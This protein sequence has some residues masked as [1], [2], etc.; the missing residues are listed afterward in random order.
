MNFRCSS[1]LWYDDHLSDCVVNHYLSTLIPLTACLASA[2][3]CLISYF[4]ARQNAKHIDTGFHP[5]ASSEDE[6][7]DQIAHVSQQ[8][9]TAIPPVIE[10]LEVALILA[11]ISIAIFLLIFSG[12]NTDLTSVFASAVSSIYLLLILFVRLTRSL[13]SY[14]DLQPHSSVLYTLQWTCLTAIVHAAILGN[15]ERNFT[16]ATL[17]R[18]ALFTFLCLFHWTAP[19]IPVEP[20]DEDHVLFLDP[21]EDETASLLSRMTFSWLDKLV[22]KAYRATLQV[23]DLYQL[24]HNHRSGVVAP[25]FKNTATNSLLWRLFGFFKSDLLWQG[26]WATLNSFAVFV[27]PVLM[28]SLLEYLEVPDLASQSTA[29]LY[30]T[31]LLVAGIVAGVAGC[32]CDWKGREMAARTRA[33]LINEIYTKVLRKGVA[34]HLQTNSEQPE[35][36][37]N[38]ASD[39]NIFNLL[40][41]DTEHV[42]EM[43]GYL[44]LVWITFPVQTAIGTYLLYRL[45]GISGIVGVALMLGLLPLNILI[46]RRLVA[47]QARVLTASDARIQASSEILNNVRTIKYS[48][49]EAVFKK[50]VLSK[51]RI[52]L[53]E[54]RSRFIWWSINMTTFFSLPLIVTILT[55][56]FYTVVWDN[57]MGTAVAFPALVIFS[58]LRIPFN[59]IADAI[60]F[61]L[62]AHVSLGRIEKFLQEQETGKYEQL[63]RTDSV[64]VGF[65]NATLTWPNGGFGNKA[66][67]E[68]KRSDIQLTELPSMRPFKL[69]GLNIRFQP[70]ALN[71]IC[72]PSGSG[73][74]SLLLALLGEMALVN[75][76]VFLPHK[77]NWH[78]LST[79]SLTE[80]TAYCPQEAWILNRTIRANIVF[81]LPFDGRR[82]EAVLE[83]VAL[84]PDIASFD[85]GDQTLAG[86]GGSRLSGGQK[87]RVSLARALYSRSKYVLLDDCL[88]A[89]DSKT[90]N[91][92]FF[93]AVK[94][95]LMQGRTCMFATNSIQLTIPHCDYIV[96]LDDGRVRGQGTAEELVSEGRI[97]ADIMQNKAEFG[98][99]KPGAYDTIE[100]DHAIK[101]PSSRSSLDTVSLLEV[102]PQ[103]EDPEAGY[104]ESKAEGAVAWSVIRTYLVTLGPPWYW[105]L[106]L[107]MFG[108]QQFIS[109][110]TNIWI[111]EWA[112]RYDMLDNFA[113]DPI[114][115]NATTR[116][117]TLDEPEEPQKVQAR[118]YM[119]IY[120]AICLAYAFFTFARDLIVFYGS[121]KASSEIYERLLNSVL[122]AKLLFFDRIPLGQITNR[123]SRDVEVL[124]QNISTFSINTLQIAAS[125]V[126]IIVFISSVVPAFLIAAVFICVAYWFV[127]TIFINGARDLRRIESVERSPVYQQFSEALSG[128]VSIRAYARASIF[129]AQN[130]VLVDRLNSPY[131]LQWASQQ[132]LGFRVNFLGSLILFFTGAFVVWDLESVDPS[133]AALVLTY[134]AMFSESIMWFVQLYAI[135]QQNLNSVERVVE[136]TEIE[137]EANQPLKRAVYDLPEDWPSRGGVRFD[138]YTTR[139][140][141]ELPPVLNDITFN[142][143]PGKRVAVVGR[144][145]AGKSTLTLALIR[146]L[147]AELGRIEIDGI[148]ISEVT[149]DR[150]RQAVTVVPQDPG[151]FRGTLRDNLD[152]LHL[153]SNEEMIETLR[154]VRLLDAVRTYIP[155]NS[156]TPLDCLDHPANA[157]SRGQRQLLCIAR[158]LLR[159][160]RVLV[161]DEATASIDH[162][163]D[164][165][166]QESLRASV[167][168]GTTV[169]TVAHRLLT[170]AD[171][172]KVVVLDAGCV[173]EQGSVQELL[174][175]DDD[176]IFRRLCVQSGDLEKIERV[177]AEKS[178][179]K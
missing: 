45:L 102:D 27:P 29:W 169:I 89:V 68:N 40:T 111:K 119:A 150:L 44:Y 123:F 132:W 87:Q 6:A 76:Q 140:A 141:P 122:F 67:T 114:Q 39:G 97:D 69:K 60:T 106:V 91:H 83:A 126:M 30:V 8:Y 173:A 75:G 18:F 151:V 96:L 71:V 161:F 109:L 143:P 11:E 80:T 146:G 153:Y 63:S 51:R 86:E 144:T 20:Y 179:R 138:A 147:E 33:V 136:Y 14:V 77:H 15:S 46:S 165:A 28:R 31:G 131:L 54:M 34:L 130:Q 129:T 25:R 152:P 159:R 175:R 59:R 99:E 10:K 82:Y 108:I 160:S 26:A 36:A 118:Y 16:I 78:E 32:Q 170:I 154:A 110:A 100:L 128:C 103:Q 64:E 24:N 74:S 164:A 47:V 105:V 66:V 41:V 72:G 134:A 101:S 121:L 57:S 133:S 127:M 112:V 139:Y 116:D 4:H 168:V 5:V 94:G 174:D 167:T 157:L 156:A 125:L 70:G 92:I 2:I 93:H 1:P 84:R 37:D 148:D 50:R 145:G 22:W 166:I 158:T 58:I 79:D 95:D 81:D 172:D 135:V 52:E 107:F 42:S 88:S 3:A 115:R 176:G 38:F 85:Q 62:R 162:T 23:S 55:L 53:V 104:E 12:E 113:F 137:Q 9:I 178:G 56:F 48:A 17:V 120:V 21:S 163:T 117:E 73:K 43:S 155:G 19:R 65:N 177:A 149:L 142:V 7:V 61:L 124:D 13:Q 49:W 90:A 98:S 171:Y 35:A